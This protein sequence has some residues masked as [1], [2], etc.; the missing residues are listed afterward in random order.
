MEAETAP[1]SKRVCGGLRPSSEADTVWFMLIWTA[2][3]TEVRAWT[4][5]RLGR[6]VLR[7]LRSMDGAVRLR[8]VGGGEES[9]LANE[10]AK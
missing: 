3:R 2:E 1:P 9:V 4:M 10:D 8:D 5:R 7:I 6:M